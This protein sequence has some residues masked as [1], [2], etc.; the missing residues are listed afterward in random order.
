MLIDD[1]DECLKEPLMKRLKLNDI[2]SNDSIKSAL[3]SIK[4]KLAFPMDKTR[5]KIIEINVCN[6]L[7]VDMI[8]IPRKIQKNWE[9]LVKKYPKCD[10]SRFVRRLS[11]DVKKGLSTWIILCHL[12]KKEM[13][14][15]PWK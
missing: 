6:N 3:S 11:K 8:A 15:N 12:C 4:V 5:S 7:D 2:V 10:F 1:N 14:I 9:L 13:C